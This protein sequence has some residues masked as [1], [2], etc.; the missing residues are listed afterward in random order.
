[1]KN[2]GGYKQ[3]YSSYR[4]LYCEQPRFWLRETLNGCDNIKN[5]MYTAGVWKGQKGHIHTQKY[6]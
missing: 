6:K 5:C 3:A 1:M 2:I 4:N